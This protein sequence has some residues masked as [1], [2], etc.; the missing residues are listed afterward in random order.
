MPLPLTGHLEPVKLVNFVLTEKFLRESLTYDLGSI[1]I[2]MDL[3]GQTTRHG[4]VSLVVAHR[5]AIPREID[6]ML[7]ATETGCSQQQR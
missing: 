6:D 2:Q 4:D 3:R 5:P 7:S 1:Q